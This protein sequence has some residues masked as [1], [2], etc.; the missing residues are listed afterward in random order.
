MGEKER[1]SVYVGVG[2]R[3]FVCMRVCVLVSVSERD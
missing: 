2:E 1:V 3:E